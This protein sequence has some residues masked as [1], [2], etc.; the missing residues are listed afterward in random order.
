MRAPNQWHGVF[1]TT[2]KSPAAEFVFL[3][4][5]GSD[6]PA[7]LASEKTSAV[8]RR[9]ADGWQVSVD[10]KIVTLAGETASVR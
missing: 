3:M 5:I 10:G 8:A 6:C 2:G 7:P 4:R 9:T 1:M